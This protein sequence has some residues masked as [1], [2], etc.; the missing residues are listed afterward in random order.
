MKPSTSSFFGSCLGVIV[1]FVLIFLFIIIMVATSSKPQ[2]KSI[3]SDSVLH[4]KL[5]EAISEIAQPASPMDAIFGNAQSGMKLKRVCQLIENASTDKKIKG[6]LIENSYVNFGQASLL[7]VVESLEKFKESGKFIYS[8]SDMHSQSSY[9]LSSVA[10]SMFLNP[11]GGIDI[12]GYGAMIPFFKGMLDKVG[13]EMNIFYAGNFK[14]ATEPFRLTEMS[15][16]NKLQTRAFLTEMQD[17]FLDIVSKNRNIDKLTLDSLVSNYESRTAKRALA[18]KLIDG[19]F[20]HDELETFI[21]NKLGTKEGKDINYVS[22]SKYDGTVNIKEK[23]G[24]EKIAVVYAEGDIVYGSNESGLISEKKYLKILDEIRDDKEIKAVVLRVNSPGGNAYS[25]ELIWRA[26]ENIKASGKKVIA[27]FGDIAASGG[28]Y[29]SAGADHIVAQPNTL[30]GSI[31]VFMMFPNATKLS[32]EKIGVRF[33]TVKTNPM[34]ISFTPFLNLTEQEKGFLQ[35]STFEI[36]DLF[37]ERVSTGRKMS[38]DSTKEI[39]QGRVW[40]G[41]AAKDVGLVDELGGLEVAIASAAKMAGLEN[42]V[43]DEYPKAKS[44]FWSE[45][46]KGIQK[47]KEEEMMNMIFS[48]TEERKVFEQIRKIKD[49][50]K[51]K[52]VIA[53][54]PYIFEFN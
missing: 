50:S 34:A 3:S 16:P 27:S 33:D 29:I 54:L 51:G 15:E 47:S 8:Y 36:Y 19:L 4:L 42:Y 14:S 22:L 13:V 25:S 32:N 12:K 1:S 40:T 35:E 45:L 23:K 24:K 18:S 20:Y 21:K 28:Y 17:I 46:V 49:V 48:T 37:L 53:R 2:N 10:D 5:D 9:L 31:G 26:I 41:N 6:I 52:Q 39:A 7:S 38:L 30:T 44:D 11:Q 43:L